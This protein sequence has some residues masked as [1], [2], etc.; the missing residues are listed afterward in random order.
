MMGMI[1]TIFGLFSSDSTVV[2]LGMY[3]TLLGM[4]GGG[5]AWTCNSI[6]E[7]GFSKAEVEYLKA[8]DEARIA[9]ESEYELK[10]KALRERLD[11]ASDKQKE[12]KELAEHLQE[13]L[14]NRPVIEVYKTI[15]ETVK[16]DCTFTDD[17][18]FNRVRKQI[19][20]EAPVIPNI[21]Q[22]NRNSD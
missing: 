7:A 12:A 9:L 3:I 5:V 10:L 4:L 17:D 21:S 6:Y 11:K 19:I 16:S 8:A 15:Y 2:R 18:N 20:G 14:T 1:K 22:R 13:E